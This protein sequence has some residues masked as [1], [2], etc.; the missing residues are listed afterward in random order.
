MQKR[1]VIGIV[2]LLTLA[3]CSPQE[4]PAPARKPPAVK[5]L[6]GLIP[7]RNLFRQMER[8]EPL[9]EYLARKTGTKITFKLRRLS[10]GRSGFNEENRAPDGIV[11][12]STTP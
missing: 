12:N 5:L 6:I 3:A 9:G 4:P 11:K 8:Y 7:E 2:C 1:S 10:A